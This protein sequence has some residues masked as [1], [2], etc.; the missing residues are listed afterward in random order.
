MN[1]PTPTPLGACWGAPLRR[2]RFRRTSS[3]C[4]WPDGQKLQP[5]VEF[6]TTVARSFCSRG[7]GVR[8]QQLFP[9]HR[10]ESS[11]CAYSY[12]HSEQARVP[13]TNRPRNVP[14]CGALSFLQKPL[15]YRGG[16]NNLCSTFYSGLWPSFCPRV[17]LTGMSA[18][19]LPSKASW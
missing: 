17:W 6:H 13:R 18:S 11:S 15:N 3:S 14:R 19:H 2:R 16:Q 1:Q 4:T 9:R 8:Y 5:R 12:E 10:M 7:T